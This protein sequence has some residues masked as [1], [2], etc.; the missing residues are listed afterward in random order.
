MVDRIA[1]HRDAIDREHRKAVL[2]VVI[3]SVIAER[4]LERGFVT[5]LIIGIDRALQHNLRRRRYLQVRAEA[6][7]HLG[8]FAAQQTGELV[9]GQRVRHRRD[10]ADRGGRIR[11][12]RHRDGI[13]L[14]GIFRAV[15]TE[16]QCAAAMCQPAHDHLVRCNHLLAVDA[17]VLPRLVRPARD[18][19]SPGDQRRHVPRPAG[20]HRQLRQINVF[21]LPHDVLAGRAGDLL[22][23]HVHQLPADG[24]PALHHIAK[25]L[26]RLRLL[27]KGEQSADVTQRF[28]RIRL[29]IGAH[30]QCNA[31]RRAE[32]IAKHRHGV[33]CRLLEQQRRPCG[34]QHA[35]ADLGHL[36]L[37]RN[38]G[39]D[40]PELPQCFELVQK[41]AQV[42]IGHVFNPAK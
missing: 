9:L 20:L 1:P 11:A 26:G 7:R 35:V 38:F 30:R 17:Q 41:I 23:R 18:G 22:R 10:R 36:E 6:F 25:T 19:Q 31:A 2:L 3:A 42:A 28:Q 39:A 29:G 32:E 8:A 14:A 21:T 40:A 4:A 24:N 12:Q 33:P 34:L 15:V 37:R 16:I 13:G 5:T 27:Q